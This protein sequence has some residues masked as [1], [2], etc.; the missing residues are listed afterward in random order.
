MD[1]YQA[2][3]KF[4]SGFNI[5]A[6]D[7]LSVPD[8]AKMPYITFDVY[9]AGYDEPVPLSASVFYSGKTWKEVAAKAKEIAAYIGGGIYVP[10]DSGAI[11]ITKGAPFSQYM[12]DEGDNVRRIYINITAEFIGD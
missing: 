10:Y 1:K 9:E 5:P 11:L 6:Y 12:A 8:S 7:E 3:Y 4:W 2:I